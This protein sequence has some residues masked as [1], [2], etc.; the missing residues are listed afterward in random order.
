[1]NS[2]HIS[3]HDLD[4]YYLGMIS[5]KFEIARFEKHLLA[6]PKCVARAEASDQYV[7]AIGQADSRIAGP[8]V[9][10]RLERLNQLSAALEQLYEERAKLDQ[11]IAIMEKFQRQ[12]LPVL[13]RRPMS[14]AKR[15]LLAN[16]LKK[17]EGGRG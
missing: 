11:V 6:C 5:D 12:T 17:N 4:R 2:D 3:D 8:A 1:M 13:R 16:G 7:A 10:I 14:K 15:R 9:C